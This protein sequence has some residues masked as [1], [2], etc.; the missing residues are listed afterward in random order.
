MIPLWLGTLQAEEANLLL[1]M[2]LNVKFDSF[3][4]QKTALS[5]LKIHFVPFLYCHHAFAVVSIHNYLYKGRA[6]R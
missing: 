3:P 2:L 4:I 1:D 5:G 6:L